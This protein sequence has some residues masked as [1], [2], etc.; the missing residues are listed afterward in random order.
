MTDIND[1]SRA[2]L[3]QQIAE[4]QAKLAA[5]DAEP[6]WEPAVVRFMERYIEAAGKGVL[7]IG[8]YVKPALEAAL[9]LAPAELVDEEAARKLAEEYSEQAYREEDDSFA[10][11]SEQAAYLAIRATLSRSARWPG[12]A[13]LREMALQSS[14]TLNQTIRT[15][16]GSCIEMA[17]RLRAHMT[18]EQA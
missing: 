4:L 10:T 2:E 6:D 1:K 3:E 11:Y 18:G 12:E 5:M 7:L 8:D 17:R 16:Y 14:C 15:N 9:P 13:E